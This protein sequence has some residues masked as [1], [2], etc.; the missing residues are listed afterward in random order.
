MPLPRDTIGSMITQRM[1]ILPATHV[2]REEL[3]GALNA[4]YADYFVPIHLTPRSF[5]DLVA[6][7]SIDLEA[8][9]VAICNGEVIGMGLL[10]IRGRRGWIGG[11]GV[12]PPYRRQGVGHRVIEYLIEQ[13]CLHRLETVQLEVIA[14]NTGARRLYESCGF[15]AARKLMVLSF[16]GG[17]GRKV[18]PPSG[19]QQPAIIPASPADALTALYR[20]PGVQRPWQRERSVLEAALA[21]LEALAAYHR[22]DGRLLG[23][24]LSLGN[25]T[26]RNLLDLAATDAEVGRL[27]LAALLDRYPL[28][29][30][31]YLNVAED[32][33]LLP[34]LLAGGF[35]E[36]LR[37]YEMFL[38]LH[39]EAAHGCI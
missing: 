3:I 18:A 39:Q 26:H 6:R 13:A 32:D 33:P 9:A 29:G 22:T 5:D 12:L 20:L 16:M 24:C 36:S 14:Q 30:F 19:G 10:A 27:L 4:A 17:E 1:T 25:T 38:S 23:V 31:S 37:Q 15:K 7:E 2:Q 28:A 8:S 21:H 35:T 11:M 34:T